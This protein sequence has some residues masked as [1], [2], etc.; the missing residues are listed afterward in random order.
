MLKIM[1]LDI[2]FK[3]INLEIINLIILINE[4]IN[5][6]ILYLI[7]FQSNPYFLSFNLLHPKR[8]IQ[9]LLKTRLRNTNFLI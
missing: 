1:E 3:K 9:F 8:N 7:S 5:L 4:I 2:L 6:L